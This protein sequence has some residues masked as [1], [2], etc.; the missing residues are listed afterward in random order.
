MESGRADALTRY[1]PDPLGAVSEADEEHELSDVLHLLNAEGVVELVY[2]VLGEPSRP[3]WRRSGPR[4]VVCWRGARALT[5]CGGRVAFFDQGAGRKAGRGRLGGGSPC[6]GR[7]Q[8]DARRC[9]S[10]RS[11]KP[12]EPQPGSRNSS[13]MVVRPWESTNYL[14]WIL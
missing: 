13:W 6:A 12:P 11:Q 4:A 8:L 2:E 9:R 10:C 7:G 14:P 1:T 3:C 5:G